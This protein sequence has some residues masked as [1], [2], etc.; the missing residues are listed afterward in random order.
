MLNTG[1]DLEV[2]KLAATRSQSKQFYEHILICIAMNISHG[3]CLSHA[4][5]YDEK[6]RKKKMDAHHKYR[7]KFLLIVLI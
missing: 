6:K 7:I 4:K 2:R 3:V 5:T 1:N